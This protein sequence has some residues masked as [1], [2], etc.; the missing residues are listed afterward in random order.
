MRSL[1]SSIPVKGTYF[2][3]RFNAARCRGGAVRR[4]PYV[5]ERVIVMARTGEWYSIQLR[6]RYQETDAMGVVY[7]GNYL[8]WFEIV[9]TEWTRANGFTYHEIEARGL[10]LPVVDV[11]IQY[12]QPARYDDEVE[13]RTR[14]TDIGPIRLTFEYDLR[15]VK[16]PEVTIATGTSQHVWVDRDWKPARLSKFAP[17]VYEAL[18]QSTADGNKE[19][20][21]K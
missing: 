16:Q 6:V 11:S 2:N 1:A 17:E 21:G 15:L 19:M 5:F 10:Y 7:H 9:R 3:I 4:C 14:V 18:L 20:A 13:V 8:T 12:K